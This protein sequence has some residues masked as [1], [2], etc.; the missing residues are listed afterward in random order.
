MAVEEE[1]FSRQRGANRCG[2]MSAASKK[3][4]VR[5]SM[6][7]KGVVLRSMSRKRA[8]LRQQCAKGYGS[9]SVGCKK[10]TSA[11]SSCTRTREVGRFDLR[12]ARKF[13]RTEFPESAPLESQQVDWNENID[14]TDNFEVAGGR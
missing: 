8:V 12:S 9:A 10:K 11:V 2:F 14:W 6:E 3:S 7:Q 5:V 4:R 1:A 13:V